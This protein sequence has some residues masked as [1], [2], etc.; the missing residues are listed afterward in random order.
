MVASPETIEDL[1]NAGGTA[2]KGTDAGEVRQ[3]KMV[4]LRKL[5]LAN[6]NEKIIAQVCLL[7]IFHIFL[8]LTFL[9]NLVQLF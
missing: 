3:L 2:E 8:T 7:L 4:Q 5:S 1:T 6:D 9:H